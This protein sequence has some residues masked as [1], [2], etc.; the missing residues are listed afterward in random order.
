MVQVEFYINDRLLDIS[1]AKSLGIKLSR[2]IFKPAEFTS[3][4]AQMSYKINIPATPTNN[5]IFNYANVEEVKD[6]FNYEY[7]AKVYVDYILVFDGKFML[8]EITESKYVGNLYIPAYKSVKDIFGERVMN[9]PSSNS[10]K[11]KWLFNITKAADITNWN[12]QVLTNF[13][14]N[15][16]NNCLFPY[17]LYGLIPKVSKTP[18]KWENGEQVGDFTDKD[19]YDSYA[20]LGYEDVPP[21]MNVLETIKHLFKSNDLSI[22]GTAFDDDRL[23]HLYMSYSNPTDYNQEWN[24]GDLGK[25]RIVGDW[26]NGYINNGTF[27]NAEAHINFDDMGDGRKYNNVNLFKCNNT[28]Y[29]QIDDAGTNVIRNTYKDKYGKT[30]NDLSLVIPKDGY[31]KISLKSKINLA[32]SDKGKGWKASATGIRFTSAWQNN[33]HGNRNN[34]FDRSQYELQL[35]RD[36][37]DG[38][39]NAG[40]C[41]GLNKNPNFSFNNYNDIPQ[42]YPKWAMVIDPKTNQHFINGLKWGQG[43]WFTNPKDDGT[44]AYYMFIKNGWSWDKQFSQK[45]KILSVYDSR[46]FGSENNYWGYTQS[47]DDDEL[48]AGDEDL[49]K[50]IWKEMKVRCGKILNAPPSYCNTMKYPNTNNRNSGDGSV[51]SIIYLHKGERLALHM[52]STMADRQSGGHGSH[53]DDYVCIIDKLDFDLTIEPFRTDIGYSNFDINGNYSESQILNWNDN[54]NFQ[55]GYIDLCKFLP[56][57]VKINDFLDNFCK[58]FNL[59]LSQPTKD[60]FLL[61]VKQTKSLGTSDIVSF[62]DKFNIKLRTN[63]PL[64]LPSEINIKWNIAEDE[65]GY[66]ESG[67]Y[68]GNGNFVTGTIGGKVS[69]QASTF[70]YNWYKDIKFKKYYE[71]ESDPVRFVEKIPII[72]KREVWEEPSSEDY[73]EMQKKWYT[74]LP[75]RFFYPDSFIGAST[76]NRYYVFQLGSNDVDLLK[77]SNEYNKTTV[78]ILDYENKEHSILNNYFTIITTNDTNYTTIETYLTPEEYE[79]LDGRNLIKLN[80]DLYYV[81]SVDGYDPLMKNPCKIKLIR[82]I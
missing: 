2:Q 78:S 75:I 64:G 3:K 37:G 18:D 28:Y 8:Q 82:K 71:D 14:N 20:R 74:N 43:D 17:I 12:Q 6:K 54:T 33:A 44:Y 72:S 41:V 32:Y 42:F 19:L 27:Y 16:S 45:E 11:N 5:N 80:S 38:D 79:L 36:F 9:N 35:L 7:D 65:E 52:V 13:N 49:P 48:N 53:F 55:K 24:Y 66:V 61:D 59:K 63:E 62:E 69:E 22:S 1:D 29:S 39:F 25:V 73:I 58:A 57:E 31:Y 23:K 34:T 56:S 60:N 77:V 40:T 26:N 47:E 50:P 51:N 68:T 70:S 30:L 15:K 4:D 81:S 46:Y 67:G 76:N 21:A 10:E